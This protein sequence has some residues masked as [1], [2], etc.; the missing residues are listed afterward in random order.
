MLPTAPV[1]EDLPVEA[2]EDWVPRDVTFVALVVDGPEP[3]RVR[4]LFLDRAEGEGADFPFC[5]DETRLRSGSVGAADDGAG[6]FFAAGGGAGA[7][8]GGAVL[9][10]TLAVE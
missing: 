5:R 7:G 2:R 4:L 10:T 3:I 9:G 6:A 8:A 1:E